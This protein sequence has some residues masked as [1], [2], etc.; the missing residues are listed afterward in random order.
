[1]RELLVYLDLEQ[2]FNFLFKKFKYVCQ[3]SLAFIP[4]GKNFPMPGK[5]GT[6][7]VVVSVIPLVK[8]TINRSSQM[9][10]VENFNPTVSKKL[11]SFNKR[12]INGELKKI[13]DH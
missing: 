12:F 8:S 9:T 11:Y 10:T 5:T 3:V 2:L 4:Q 7:C 6:L 13:T 1:M